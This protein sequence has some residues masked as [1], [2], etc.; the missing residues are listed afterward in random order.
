MTP[1][2]IMIQVCINNDTLSVQLKADT[3]IINYKL[4]PAVIYSTNL[5][6]SA[7]CSH[8]TQLDQGRTVKNN[9][10]NQM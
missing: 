4:G 10:L 5:V 1:T 9:S 8:I 7:F 3:Q 6:T 2:A